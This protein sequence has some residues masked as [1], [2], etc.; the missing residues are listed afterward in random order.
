MLV[1][2][3]LPMEEMTSIAI[4]HTFVLSVQSFCGR[5]H[6]ENEVKFAMVF[7]PSI[8]THIPGCS[9]SFY[10]LVHTYSYLFTEIIQKETSF[11]RK[12]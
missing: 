11:K 2:V 12:L 10:P 7:S 6:Q 9:N 3:W 8:V 5:E 1:T 4:G